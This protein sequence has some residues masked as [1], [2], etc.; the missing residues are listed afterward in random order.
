MNVRSD[1]SAQ[2]RP[3]REE[4]LTEYRSSAILDAARQVFGDCGFDRATIERIA[5]V[6]GIAKGTVY[7]YYDSKRQ[8]YDDALQAGLAELEALTAARLDQAAT[9]R[10]AITAFVTTRTEY[11]LERRSF[12]R[13]YV[14]AVSSQLID[15]TEH[16]SQCRALIDRQARRLEEVLAAAV[17]A[18]RIRPVD[19][20]ATALA[21]FDLT[22]GLV[23]R[24]LITEAAPD[25]AKEI[26][27][28]VDLIWSGLET[29]RAQRK[30]RAQRGAQRVQRKQR[31]P[32]SERSRSAPREKR[33]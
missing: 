31:A 13:M 32:R 15:A 5:Q 10:D 24:R 4:V 29:Q 21:V 33:R 20:A 26:A 16:P 17:A 2:R 9:P 22:R 18:R 14:A 19:P 28:L 11:F 30:Q 25:L 12:F 3:S 8:L 7:L 1:T 23:V 6:A 27:L